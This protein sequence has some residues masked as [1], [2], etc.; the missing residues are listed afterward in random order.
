MNIFSEL[1]EEVGESVS[2]QLK[3]EA[4]ET[5]MIL[6]IGETGA[7]KSYFINTIAPGSCK[8]SARLESCKC[9]TKG[10]ICARHFLT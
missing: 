10:I 4:E 6:V 3:K 5:S 2:S 9:P 8:T 7:G 1:Q